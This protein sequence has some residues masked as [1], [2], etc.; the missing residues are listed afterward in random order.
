V[1]DVDRRL[2][3]LDKRRA[4]LEEAYVLDGAIDREA[5]TGLSD[6]LSEERA[7]AL[8]G[9]HEAELEDFDVET[10]MN[11]AESMALN[12][13]RLWQEA[14]TEEKGLARRSWFPLASHGTVSDLEPS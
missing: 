5:Y 1:A 11:Y 14:G 9:R 12:P 10:L 7:L 8:L 2:A 4:R 13:G 6:R 3:Q